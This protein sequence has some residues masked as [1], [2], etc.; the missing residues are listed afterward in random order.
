MRASCPH[1]PTSGDRGWGWAFL[2][3]G[4]PY[5]GWMSHLPWSSPTVRL[6]RFVA[7]EIFSFV[8]CTA[9]TPDTY[10]CVCHNSYMMITVSIVRSVRMQIREVG[11]PSTQ[12]TYSKDQRLSGSWSGRLREHDHRVTTGPAAAPVLTGCRSNARKASHARKRCDTVPRRGHQSS[13]R[14]RT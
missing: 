11:P 12:K 8:C 1:L 9:R 7:V 6:L 4:L 2:S 5:S 10:V 3:R 14:K 13:T